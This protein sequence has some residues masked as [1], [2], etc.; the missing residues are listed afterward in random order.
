MAERRLGQ[1]AEGGPLMTKQSDALTTDVN[2]I[3]ARHVAHGIPLPVDGRPPTYGDFASGLDYHEAMNRV[4]AAEQS[5]DQLPAH[6]RAHC[7]NNPGRFLDLVFDP[8]RIGE[9]EELGLLPAQTP[10]KPAAP[11]TPGPAP[12]TPPGTPPTP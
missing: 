8:N 3:V 2:A 12:A 7:E 5:F 11:A 1:H 6:I 9:L 10:E 4:T